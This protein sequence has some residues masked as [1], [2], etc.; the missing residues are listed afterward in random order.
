VPLVPGGAAAS[1]PQ[2]MLEVRLVR[3]SGLRSEDLIGHSDPYVILRVSERTF[4]VGQR[5]FHPATVTV[6]GQG[7]TACGTGQL[8]SGALVV[9]HNDPLK[10]RQ[11]VFPT[12]VVYTTHVLLAAWCPVAAAAHRPCVVLPHN[13]APPPLL[14]HPCCM[15]A[16]KFMACQR[17]RYRQ[18]DLTRVLRTAV[19]L[20]T[21]MLS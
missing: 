7:R 18:I 5:R 1:G 13:Q 2:G 6:W 14:S 21:G 9:S 19:V 12:C 15:C 8:R 10:H 17:F 11:H 4:R 3:I 16:A 20:E